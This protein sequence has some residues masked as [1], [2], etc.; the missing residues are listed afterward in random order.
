M[1]G[2]GANLRV[3]DE[4]T[5]TANA[6]W[7][8]DATHLPPVDDA[9]AALR[10]H[11]YVH[12]PRWLDE[13]V[14]SSFATLAHDTVERYGTRIVRFSEDDVLDHEVVT[15]EFIQS[16]ARRLFEL[17]SSDALLTWVR[18]V[19][20]VADLDLSSNLRSS[21]N[22]NC[23][24]YSGQ[25]YPWHNDA[26]PFTA[27][28][29]LTTLADSDGGEFLIRSARGPLVRI[30]PVRGDLVLL[31]GHRCAHAVAPL[32]TEVCRLT[33]PMVYPAARVARPTW[34]DKYLYDPSHR[35]E[36]ED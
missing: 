32:L 36:A 14:A 29:F 15:G 26:V 34:L 18:T 9:R 8:S 31:D 10:R 27:L 2:A 25:G 5:M 24:R 13:D 7:I 22:V 28:L 19:G 20:R 6:H 35:S 33:V 23:L 3:N 11:G 30:Q 1:K 12:V 21:I 17:Y 16:Y 4:V